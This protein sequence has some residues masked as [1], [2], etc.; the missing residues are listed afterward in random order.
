[1]GPNFLHVYR[2]IM[3]F[4]RVSRSNANVSKNLDGIL[5]IKV[6]RRSAPTSLFLHRHGRAQ[7]WVC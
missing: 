6:K 3:Q 1:M 2:D 4:S 7:D 5:W